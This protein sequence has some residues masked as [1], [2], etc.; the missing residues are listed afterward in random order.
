MGQVADLPYDLI[1]RILCLLPAKSLLI[2]CCVCKEWFNLIKS[3]DF[4]EA[5]SRQTEIVF[6][7]LKKAPPRPKSF[8]IEAKLGL[9][10]NSSIFSKVE[11][12]RSYI[13]FVEFQGGKCKVIDSNI[14]GFKDILATC[15]G[16]ILATCEQNGGLLVLNPVT[17]KLSALPLGT[18][19][20]F[21][22]SYGFVF[23]HLTKQ[24]KVVHLFQDEDR[25]TS[26]EILSLNTRSWWG[27]DGPSF[28]LVRSLDHKPVSAI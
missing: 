4:I 8:T 16:L 26:C 17:R 3:L 18:S 24:Y 2:L 15:K 10:V 7:F 6:I 27:V 11:P 23:S 22:Q 25:H 28:G 5:H 9:L 19:L 21:E 1:F 12:P 20:P 13:N 14:S